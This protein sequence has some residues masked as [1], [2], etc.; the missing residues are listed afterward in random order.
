MTDHCYGAYI[1]FDEFPVGLFLD[2]AYPETPGEYGYMP[3]RAVGHY[4]MATAVRAGQAPRCTWTRGG[5][6]VSFDVLSNPRYGI[7]SIDN[8]AVS[9]KAAFEAPEPLVSNAEPPPPWVVN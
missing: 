6:S 5:R 2:G 8:F 1:K 4:N 9:D 3:M 7:L